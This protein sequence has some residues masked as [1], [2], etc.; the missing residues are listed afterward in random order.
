MSSLIPQI[1]T[2]LDDIPNNF[3]NNIINSGNVEA[4]ERIPDNTFDGVITSPP[5]ADM[6]T[7]KTNKCKLRPEWDNFCYPARKWAN[8]LYRT[9]KNGG[10]IC[11]NVLNKKFKGAYND[12]EQRLVQIFKEEGFIHCE[13]QWWNK[14]FG[15]AHTADK[16]QYKSSGNHLEPFYILSKGTLKTY[17]PMKDKMGRSTKYLGDRLNEHYSPNS[18]ACWLGRNVGTNDIFDHPC[19]FSEGIIHVMLSIYFN[20]GDHVLDPF[21]GSGTVGKCARHMGINY[22]CIDMEREYCDTSQKRIMSDNPLILSTPLPG[23]DNIFTP[24]NMKMSQI[25]YILHKLFINQT[26]IHSDD[27][28]TVEYNNAII[29]ITK[30][31]NECIS[32]AEELEDNISVSPHYLINNSNELLSFDNLLRNGYHS[33][34]MIIERNDDA[35]YRIEVKVKDKIIENCRHMNSGP[36]EQFYFPQKV[37]EEEKKAA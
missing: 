11:L 4:L 21:S 28:S 34:T 35:L 5:Y 33:Y 23:L 22:T 14:G 15:H 25:S 16:F 6:K 18:G 27:V 8:Q 32:I 10:V 24:R 20:Q 19:P 13:T 2:N 29:T 30:L 1:I 26:S 9:V 7:Y 36:M 17:N 3:I 37:W 12:E 31:G